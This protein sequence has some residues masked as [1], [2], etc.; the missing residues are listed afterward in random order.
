LTSVS[1][2]PTP[3]PT[4]LVIAL[5]ANDSDN[6]SIPLATSQ[7]NLQ[8]YLTASPAQC[9]YL[10]NIS[11]LTVSW[12]LPTYGPPYNAMLQSLANNSNGRIHVADW[13]SEVDANPAILTPRVGRTS[14]P[15]G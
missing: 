9:V 8:N 13:A 1:P 7:S 14:P 12:G 2:F 5:G 11:T 6:G 10:V 3:G 4:I 15:P